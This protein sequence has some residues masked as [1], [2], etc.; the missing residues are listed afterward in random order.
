MRDCTEHATLFCEMCGNVSYCHNHGVLFHEH[1]NFSHILKQWCV[2]RFDPATLDCSRT[3]AKNSPLPCSCSHLPVAPSAPEV[4]HSGESPSQ[5]P[6]SSSGTSDDEAAGLSATA[7]L[8]NREHSFRTEVLSLSGQ[9]C[10]VEMQY[11]GVLEHRHLYLASYGYFPTNP[12]TLSQC[13]PV[14]EMQLMNEV[15]S[16]CMSLEG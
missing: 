6:R 4:S 12:G 16:L 7:S 1:G 15:S 9:S 13:F 10:T 11:C 14:H 2:G 3:V 5:S 8:V